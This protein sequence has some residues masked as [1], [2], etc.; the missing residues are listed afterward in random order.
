MSKNKSLRLIGLMLIVTLVLGL[1]VPILSVSAVQPVLT[2]GQKNIV[3]RARQMTE[4]QW[5]PQK[6]IV[7]WGWGLTYQ[8]GV[9]YKGLPYGQP[10]NASYVPW[11]T[12][13]EGF[14]DAVNDP[15]SLMYT[16][17]SSSNKR[18]PYYSVDCSAFVSWAWNLG[19]RQS[20]HSI[21]Q[22]ATAISTSSYDDAQVGD[23]LNK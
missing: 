10:V 6:N 9:T 14:L 12:S 15:N 5:T 21:A 22:F 23:C 16:S 4:I 11:S 8:A 17:Y 13:L 7:G 18:A 3:K 2:Q 1:L 19:S 20:T